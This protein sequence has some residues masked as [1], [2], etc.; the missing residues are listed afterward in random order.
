MVQLSLLFESVIQ[1][2]GNLFS[3][4]YTIF[5]SFVLIGS[6]FLDKIDEVGFSVKSDAGD[7]PILDALFSIDKFG[8]EDKAALGAGFVF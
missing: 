1:V 5:P 3:P 4:T 8:D 2:L 6:F 7:T